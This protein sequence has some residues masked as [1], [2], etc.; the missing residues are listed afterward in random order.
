LSQYASEPT[1]QGLVFGFT[2]FT[3]AE[4]RRGVEKMLNLRLDQPMRPSGSI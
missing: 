3:P 2:A 1:E 4:I